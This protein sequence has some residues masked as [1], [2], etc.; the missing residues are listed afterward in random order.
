MRNTF[1]ALVTGA[2]LSMSAVAA[3]AAPMAAVPH[4]GPSSELVYV[5]GG[6]GMAGH[7]NRF[8]VCVPNGFFRPAPRCVIRPTPAGPRRFCN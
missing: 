6:C 4:A 2:A 5:S 1:L 8:N 7:R 3:N